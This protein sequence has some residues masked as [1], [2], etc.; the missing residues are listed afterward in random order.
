MVLS[1]SGGLSVKQSPSTRGELEQTGM[2][3][4]RPCFKGPASLLAVIKGACLILGLD[5]GLCF[6]GEA[7]ALGHGG[8]GALPEPHPQLHPRLH[9]CGGGL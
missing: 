6:P 4:Q 5:L 7:A 8:A 2:P 3:E 9:C 1:L